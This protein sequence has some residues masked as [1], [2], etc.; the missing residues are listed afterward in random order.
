[1]IASLSA[2]ECSRRSSEYDKVKRS[3]PLHKILSSRFLKLGSRMN[4]P[5]EL[6]AVPKYSCVSIGRTLHKITAFTSSQVGRYTLHVYYVDVLL[7]D[8]VWSFSRLRH[9]QAIGSGMLPEV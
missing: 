7:Q 9:L 2:L 1:M 8:T 4:G 6:Y 3:D 5:I